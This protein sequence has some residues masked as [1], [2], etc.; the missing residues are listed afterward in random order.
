MVVIV[1]NRESAIWRKGN[2]KTVIRE[3]QLKYVDVE[4]TQV[5]T[6]N[7]CAAEQ[8]KHDKVENVG[9]IVG[10]IGKIEGQHNLKSV[11]DGW[12]KTWR[13]SKKLAE[14]K[15]EEHRDGRS[16]KWQRG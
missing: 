7:R 9:S 3:N 6:N 5:I 2:Q 15:I 11:R 1:M 4:E 12:S 10:K 16:Q 14:K 13:I 8:I